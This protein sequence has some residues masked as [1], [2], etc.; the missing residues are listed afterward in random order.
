MESKGTSYTIENDVIVKHHKILPHS[1]PFI[2]SV[3]SVIYSHYRWPFPKFSPIKKIRHIFNWYHLCGTW[4]RLFICNWILLLKSFFVNFP[5]LVIWLD[6]KMLP[7]ARSQV[8]SLRKV[9]FL[10]FTLAWNDWVI[11]MLTWFG[12]W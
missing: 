6:Q 10:Y 2:F 5:I 7:P 4:M 1:S 12:R 11:Y 8:N 9:K 3:Q